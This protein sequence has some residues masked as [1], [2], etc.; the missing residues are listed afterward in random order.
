LAE[1][2]SAIAKR[3]YVVARFLCSGA[4]RFIAAEVVTMRFHPPDSPVRGKPF[5]AFFQLT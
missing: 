3:A 1:S 2:S 4:E 5:I